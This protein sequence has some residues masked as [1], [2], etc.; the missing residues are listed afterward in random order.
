MAHDEPPGP[1]DD[2]VFKDDPA[3]WHFDEDI[4]EP[5]DALFDPDPGDFSVKFELVAMALDRLKERAQRA[6]ADAA[7]QRELI[8]RELYNA[9]LRVGYDPDT[10]VLVPDRIAGS[11]NRM[12]HRLVQ[13]VRYVIPLDADGSWKTADY[14]ASALDEALYQGVPP[15]V[16]QT[17]QIDWLAANSRKHLKKIPAREADDSRR[18]HRPVIITISEPVQRH[19]ARFPNQ[20]EGLFHFRQLPSS[21]NILRM[22]LVDIAPGIDFIESEARR[23]WGEHPLPGEEALDLKPK[24]TK[25]AR[26]TMNPRVQRILDGTVG[27]PRSKK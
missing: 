9:I 15:A 16:I 3:D 21:G 1:D 6:F 12:D 23:A 10:M 27:G 5:D 17:L 14:F 11:S 4:E 26:S 24:P 18:L 7:L 25:P 13:I 22:E 8:F 20:H 2:D 19:L